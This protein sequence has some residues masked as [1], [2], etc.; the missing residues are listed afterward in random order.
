MAM[1]FQQADR[2]LAIRTAQAIWAKDIN[3]PIVAFLFIHKL[4]SREQYHGFLL[5][6]GYKFAAPNGFGGAFD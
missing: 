1:N 3:E 6:H 5:F 4:N 2:L